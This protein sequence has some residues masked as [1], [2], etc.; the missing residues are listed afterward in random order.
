MYSDHKHY[1]D[2]DDCNTIVSLT[3]YDEVDV[4]DDRNTTVSSTL[5][6]ED[7][8][9]EDDFNAIISSPLPPPPPSISPSCSFTDIYS[10]QTFAIISK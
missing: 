9:V 6:D 10:N 1:R 4:E 5:Y 7:D 8:D 3:L 2:D